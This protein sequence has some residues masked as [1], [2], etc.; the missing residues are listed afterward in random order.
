[1]RRQKKMGLF[2]PLMTVRGT[3]NYR[4]ILKILNDADFSE[5]VSL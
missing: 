4:V 2:R 5:G 3:F 1:L